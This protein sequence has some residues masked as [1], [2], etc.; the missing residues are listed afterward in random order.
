V[1]RGIWH[2]L[3][4]RQPSDLLFITPAHG[5]RHRAVGTARPDG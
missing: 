5:T 4:L 3:V 1:P 2:R